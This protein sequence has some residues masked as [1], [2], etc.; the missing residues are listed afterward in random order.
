M[1]Y[2]DILPDEILAMMSN[3]VPPPITVEVDSLKNEI[4][5]R[6]SGVMCVVYPLYTD[7][8]LNSLNPFNGI[9]YI[10]HPWKQNAEKALKLIEVITSIAD[11]ENTASAILTGLEFA[12]VY[13]ESCLYIE[14]R[15]FNKRNGMK[16]AATA[17]VRIQ[18]L[19][20]L[21]YYF[22]DVKKLEG[23]AGNPIPYATKCIEKCKEG[24][25]LL[26]AQ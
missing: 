8:F 3:F 6:I 15:N 9:G 17:Q 2:F 16:M 21:E 18:F 1:C 20:L 4:H 11:E 7:E 5:L 26:S 23:W 19:K 14:T 12:I 22:I 10:G 24:I 25:A 13:G